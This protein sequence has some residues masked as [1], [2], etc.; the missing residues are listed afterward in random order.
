M[1]FAPEY[2]N[3]SILYNGKIIK[4]LP[5]PGTQKEVESISE[6]FETE[7]FKGEKASVKNFLKHYQQYEI[8]HLAMHAILNDSLPNL[9]RFVFSQ[10]PDHISKLE[11]Y[12]ADIYNLNLKNTQL[13]VLS[14]CNT[15]SGKIQKGEG[16][17][18]V[19]RG[20]LY[21]GCPSV[22][23][24]LWEA[25]DQSGTTIMNAF[26][27]YLKKGNSI[28]KALRKSKLDYLENANSRMA[29]PHYW[30]AYISIG[31]NSPMYRSRDYYFLTL[32]ILVVVG[33]GIEQFLKRRKRRF[34]KG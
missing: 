31:D 25:E 16:V 20:F 4:L 26:Y 5:L 22:V 6:H 2:N 32:I 27:S 15:G 12:T 24:T 13:A 19:S 17:M 10:N 30:L 21:A 3:D 1:A 29:H 33:I 11:L 18:S 14:A 28:D 8:L 7:I 23:M 34:Y 9:S